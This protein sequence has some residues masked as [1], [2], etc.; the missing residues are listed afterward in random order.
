MNIFNNLNVQSNY[1]GKIEFFNFLN[2]MFEEILS[3]GILES[4]YL[5][6]CY[7]L[8]QSECE[9]DSSEIT[10]CLSKAI[11][12][13]KILNEELTT[14]SLYPILPILNAT[15]EFLEKIITIINYP[16]AI[17]E[18]NEPRVKTSITTRFMNQEH[19]DEIIVMFKNGVELDDLKIAISK[20][21]KAGELTI[22]EIRNLMQNVD[23]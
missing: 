9:I 8:T 2:K 19:Y 5:I 22:S 15:T 14:L 23:D 3:N 16:Q 17:E 18:S 21:F 11:E 1:N 10:N 12:E 7:E 6:H 4:D 20:K 13:A